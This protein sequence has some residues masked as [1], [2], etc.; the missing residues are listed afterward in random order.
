MNEVTDASLRE[1]LKNRDYIKIMA[2]AGNKFLPL[3]SVEEIETC[4]MN[5]LWKALLAYDKDKIGK[6]KV[7]SK[8]TS[9]LYR[10]VI[11]ECKTQAKF[12]NRGRKNVERIS[13]NLGYIDTT[14]EFSDMF[15]EVDQVEDSDILYDYFLEN[16]TIE[17]ISQERDISKQSVSAKKLK[18]LERLRKRLYNRV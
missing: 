6:N 10:G 11:L 17:Q 15:E 9:F 2:K 14:I 8:F 13:D 16:M 12:V 18:A 4:K 1:A 5:A 7:K 3:L